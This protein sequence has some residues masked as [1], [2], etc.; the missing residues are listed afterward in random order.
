[1]GYRDAPLGESVAKGTREDTI[2][3]DFEEDR[4]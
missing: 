2:R 4:V 1:M 3:S